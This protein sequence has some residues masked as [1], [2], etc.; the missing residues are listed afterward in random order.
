MVIA[1]TF[2]YLSFLE[3]EPLPALDHGGGLDGVGSQVG[4]G[5]GHSLLHNGGGGLHDRGGNGGCP[6]FRDVLLLSA[7]LKSDTNF[8]Q[9]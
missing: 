1:S 9:I 8:S 5:H 4:V 7:F 2:W 3:D 6:L